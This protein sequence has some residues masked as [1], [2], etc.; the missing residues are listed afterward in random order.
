MNN[1]IVLPFFITTLVLSGYPTLQ[2]VQAN[3]S[4]LIA[5]SSIWKPYSSTQAGFTVLMPGTPSEESTSVKTEIGV[6]PVQLFSVVRPSEA[7]YVVAYSDL[8][9]NI[10][11]NSR[12]IEQLLSGIAAGFSEGSGGRLISQQPIKLGNVQGR[13]IRLQFSQGVISIGRIYVVNKR[14][15]QVVVATTKE[16]NLTKSIE[17]FFNSFQLLNK[18]ST[19]PKPSLEE[20]NANLRQSVCAQNWPQSVRLINQMIPLAPSSEVRSQLVTYQRRL[21]NLAAS[22]SRIPANLLTDCA[23]GR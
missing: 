13:E 18:A 3:E 20:L 14:L 9:D 16:K 21:Q 2:S 1:K 5:Q 7:V 8:P 15:Y 6:I 4:F 12:D 17:G 10:S 19:P 22:R 11:Q 23:P